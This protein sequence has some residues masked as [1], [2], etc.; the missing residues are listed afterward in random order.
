MKPEE[1][2]QVTWLF[3]P[4]GNPEGKDM[5]PVGTYIIVPVPAAPVPTEK[6]LALEDILS[7]M[8][9]LPDPGAAIKTLLPARLA[10]F[11][12]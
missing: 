1:A 11:T 7:K 2:L 3:S 12:L 9:C 10:A 8:I 6:E 5:P 4:T